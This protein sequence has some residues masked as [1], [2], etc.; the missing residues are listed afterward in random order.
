MHISIVITELLLKRKSD[1]TFRVFIQHKY[2]SILTRDRQLKS[3]IIRP[4]RVYFCTYWNYCYCCRLA[5]KDYCY[6]GRYVVVQIV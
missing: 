6:C 1:C 3:L 2:S 5:W 4:N